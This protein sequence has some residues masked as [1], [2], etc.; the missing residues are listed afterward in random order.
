MSRRL[1]IN[2]VFVQIL[3]F[4]AITWEG[5]CMNHCHFERAG[6]Q[7][8]DDRLQEPVISSAARNTSDAAREGS[9]TGAGS[10]F[11]PE[12]SPLM[13]LRARLETAKK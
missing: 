10:I 8:R 9:I 3:G 7:R 5:L 2:A 13:S 12:C 1:N 6:K 4:P 11:K